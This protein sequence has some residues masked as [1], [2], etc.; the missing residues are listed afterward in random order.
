ME[1]KSSPNLPPSIPRGF[2]L[3]RQLSWF[4]PKIDKPISHLMLC[5]HIDTYTDLHILSR[6]LCRLIHSFIGTFAERGPVSK[7]RDI[8]LL[9]H[10]KAKHIRK[11]FSESEIDVVKCHLT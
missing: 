1:T 9:F 7:C 5:A 4:I 10:L 11:F 3:F 6:T 8:L 2:T